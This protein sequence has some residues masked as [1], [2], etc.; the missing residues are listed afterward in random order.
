MALIIN[1]CKCGKVFEAKSI[2]R[3]YC[4]DCRKER[5]KEANKRAK[6]KYLT[7]ENGKAKHRA[8]GK[9]TYYRHHEAK[10]EKARRWYHENKE[11][12][13][14]YLKRKRAAEPKLCIRCHQPFDKQGGE[15]I[16]PICRGR[17]EIE[18]QRKRA[19][20]YQE[21]KIEKR[22]ISQAKE[23]KTKETKMPRRLKCYHEQMKRLGQKFSHKPEVI[24][25]EEEK[26]SMFRAALAKYRAA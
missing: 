15:R 4:D 11:Q 2:M 24:P 12:R 19:A 8:H 5:L 3:V 10:L 17:I 1:V 25:T 14:E 13:N 26:L 7:T 9:A 20:K 22:T 18:R 16:C 6:K 21:E 23:K